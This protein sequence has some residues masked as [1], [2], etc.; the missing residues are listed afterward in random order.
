MLSLLEPGWDFSVNEEL[1]PNGWVQRIWECQELKLNLLFN[2]NAAVN[3]VVKA[4]PMG[5]DVYPN[6]DGINPAGDMDSPFPGMTSWFDP[7]G[8]PTLFIFN[9]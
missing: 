7:T 6:A 8:A 3:M 5:M 2:G 4:S 1:E 9:K